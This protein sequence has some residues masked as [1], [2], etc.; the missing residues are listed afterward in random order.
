MKYPDW[1]RKLEVVQIQRKTKKMYIGTCGERVR[2][3]E[4]IYKGERQPLF[5][6]YTKKQ[7]P[8]KVGAI[9]LFSRQGQTRGTH[10]A[11]GGNSGSVSVSGYHGIT[12]QAAK[13]YRTT[14]RNQ[15]KNK[16]LLR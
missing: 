2:L 1:R 3:G 13:V 8:A 11:S 7:P 6:L 5:D 9:P 15:T 10:G 14:E 12:G 16:G 4:I